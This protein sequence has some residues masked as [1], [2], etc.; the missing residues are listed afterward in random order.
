[1]KLLA[2]SFLISAG[3]AL[4]APSHCPQFSVELEVQDETCKDAEVFVKNHGFKIFLPRAAATDRSEFNQFTCNL[5]ANITIPANYKMAGAGNVSSESYFTKKL[6]H[7][8]AEMQLYVEPQ[9]ADESIFSVPNRQR[10]GAIESGGAIPNLNFSA[11]R[12]EAK[13]FFYSIIL[14]GAVRATPENPEV[15]GSISGDY[16]QA[17]LPELVPC[18]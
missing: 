3:T 13:T 6:S 9:N 4:S 7:E 5:S 2:L 14:S 15:K 1:M 8:Y 16:I 10:G 18:G 11:C 17:T 12:G